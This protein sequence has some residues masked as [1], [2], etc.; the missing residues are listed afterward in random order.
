MATKSTKNTEVKSDE[1]VP[2]LCAQAGQIS[3]DLH[4]YLRQGGRFANYVLSVAKFP[5]WI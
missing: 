3:F 4:V 2:A 5:Y 1:D